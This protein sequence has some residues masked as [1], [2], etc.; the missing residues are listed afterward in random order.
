MMKIKSIIQKAIFPCLCILLSSNAYSQYIEESTEVK[1]IEIVEE[2]VSQTANW[3]ADSVYE[4]PKMLSWFWTSEKMDYTDENQLWVRA[5]VTTNLYTDEK[6][7]Y[8]SI[9]TYEHPL[10]I[11][12]VIASSEDAENIIKGIKRIR[13]YLLQSYKN[14]P[15]EI[16]FTKYLSLKRYLGIHMWCNERYEWEGG[17]E[18][19]NDRG[20]GEFRRFKDAQKGLDQLVSMFEQGIAAIESRRNTNNLDKL[21]SST[22]PDGTVVY[23]YKG[24]QNIDCPMDNL[25]YVKS[26]Y[27]YNPKT[28]NSKIN[29][30]IKTEHGAVK[31]N[32]YGEAEII[33]NQDGI[34]IDSKLRLNKE[35]AELLNKRTVRMIMEEIQ[36][37]K[38]ELKQSDI[39]CPVNRLR[40]VVPLSM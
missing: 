39:D 1:T 7:Y 2:Y 37:F 26:L 19:A 22:Q 6:E 23:Y 36:Q 18:L 15:E 40:F 16:Y 31:L 35:T 38:L 32:E 9:E 33:V 4:A 30:I 14:I 8:L 12:A 25:T 28:L 5:F 20:N 24:S 34:L 17:I 27:Q 21:L 13:E 10:G 29:K 3:L 11:V